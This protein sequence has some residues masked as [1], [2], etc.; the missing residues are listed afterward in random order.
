MPLT[1]PVALLWLLLLVAAP[2]AAADAQAR[3]AR[4]R[5]A[6][7]D[8]HS[9]SPIVG[10]RVVVAATGRFVTTDS[11]GRFE[12]RDIPTGVIRF[13]FAAEGYP[14]LPVVLAFAPGEVMI[15]DFELDSTQVAD[16]TAGRGRVQELPRAEVTAPASRGVRY[17]DFER[18]MRTGRGSYVTREQIEAGRFATLQDVA[19]TIRGVSV[20]CRGASTCNIRMARA[21][22]GCPPA[23]FV[24]GREDEMFGPYVAIGDIEGLEFY[25]GAS[26]V[27]GEFAGAGAGCGVVVIWTK[28][29]PPR[30]RP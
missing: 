11:L 17:E 30:P 29:G 14:R 8:A 13:I 18:R 5:G 7:L 9:R 10:A 24:D 16:T 15:Q 22:R 1:R 6:V 23:Y 2:A 28:S 20:E 25:A 26:D 27:P 4:L 19:R 12:L 3:F 21:P